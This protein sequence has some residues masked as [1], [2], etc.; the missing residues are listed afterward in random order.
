MFPWLCMQ[1][2]DV[3]MYKKKNALTISFFGY[4]ANNEKNEKE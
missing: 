1:L 2:Y 3:I 4:D